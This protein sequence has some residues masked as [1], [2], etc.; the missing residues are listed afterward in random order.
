MLTYC[1]TTF[2]FSSATLLDR[3]KSYVLTDE[4]V[5]GELVRRTIQGAANP[6]MDPTSLRLM[7]MEKRFAGSIAESGSCSSEL[8][9]E[10]I[11]GRTT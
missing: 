10:K 7:E 4:V 9:M 3:V 5:I 1:S 8:R 2:E 6:S 11:N